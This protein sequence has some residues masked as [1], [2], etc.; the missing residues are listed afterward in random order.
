MDRQQQ[1]TARQS[2]V[3]IVTR[4]REELAEFQRTYSSNKQAVREA[5]RET[6]RETLREALL[7]ACQEAVFQAANGPTF[8][9]LSIILHAKG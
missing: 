4:I 7:S 3:D 9:R 2:P 6:L 8:I 1:Y 5:L